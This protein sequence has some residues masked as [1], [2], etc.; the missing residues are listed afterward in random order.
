M[1]GDPDTGKTC[2]GCTLC[3]KLL[4]VDEIDKPH[5]V[6]C[7]H[8]DKGRGCGIYPDR[9]QSCRDFSCLWLKSKEMGEDLRPDRIRA[10]LD[11]DGDGDAIV[12]H[13]DPGYPDAHR[14]NPLH[15]ILSLAAAKGRVVVIANGARR[16][17][18]DPAER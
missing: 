18:F 17:P 3:C 6:W 8:C 11:S 1:P 7:R 12:V 2:G 9:P 5:S 13:I 10:V 14:K 16:K 15:R 4:S